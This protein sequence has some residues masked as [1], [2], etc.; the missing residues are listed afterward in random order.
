MIRERGND[1]FAWGVTAGLKET[2][3]SKMKTLY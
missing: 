1:A 2:T 3:G